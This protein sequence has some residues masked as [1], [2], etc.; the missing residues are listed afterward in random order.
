MLDAKSVWK[1]KARNLGIEWIDAAIT[2]WIGEL[3]GWLGAAGAS[4]SGAA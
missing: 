4:E 1:R 2:D 3:R